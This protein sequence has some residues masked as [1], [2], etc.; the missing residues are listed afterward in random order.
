MVEMLPVSGFHA[1]NRKEVLPMKKT[2]SLIL[3]F[4]LAFT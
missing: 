2:V 3:L 1:L 4:A